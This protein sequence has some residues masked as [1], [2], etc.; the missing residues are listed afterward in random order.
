V[1][2]LE[3]SNHSRESNSAKRK[4]QEVR[5][6]PLVQKAVEIFKARLVEIEEPRG[7]SEE[8]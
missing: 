6:H 4:S 1:P 8:I 7:Q 3:N 2:V 5:S